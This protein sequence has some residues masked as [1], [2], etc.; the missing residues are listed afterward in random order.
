M[1]NIY[2]STFICKKKPKQ[3]K[4]MKNL[5]KKLKIAAYFKKK[6]KINKCILGV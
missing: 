1:I 3:K 5:N 2:F 6:T 4:L